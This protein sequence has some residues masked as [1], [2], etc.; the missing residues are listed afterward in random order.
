MGLTGEKTMAGMYRRARKSRLRLVATAA[1]AILLVAGCGS[2]GHSSERAASS[3]PSGAASTGSSSAPATSVSFNLYP[4]TPYSWLLNFAQGEGFFAKNGIKANLVPTTG[5]PPAFAGLASGSLQFA[6][7][8]MINGGVLLDNGTPLELVSGLM[9]GNQT[10]LI[11]SQAA[12]LPSGFPAGIKG[13]AGKD[14]GVVSVGSAAYYYMHLFLGAAGMSPNSVTYAATTVAPASLV[15][16]LSGDRV[17]AAVVSLATGYGL[18][19]V[20]HDPVL[21]DMD[22]NTDSLFPGSV[23]N[24]SMLPAGAPLQLL[25]DRVHQYLWASKP[26][27]QAHSAVVKR[28]QLALEETDVWLHNPTNLQAAVNYLLNDGGVVKFPGETAEQL[29]AFLATEV[30]LLVSYVP[31]AD[32]ATYQSVYVSQGILKSL[33]LGQ[34]MA[35]GVPA[36]SADVVNAVDA[37]GAGSLGI[38]G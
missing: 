37:A 33:P 36:S 17:A 32:V 3:G 2:S 9:K 15:A 19:V 5:A 1:A 12:H 23:P 10:L 30:P 6:S 4:G 29:Q 16:A 20:D 7:G 18:A 14:V 22:I 38:A 34:F 26:W 11:G 35:P 25:A 24:P 13:L 28:V 21:F 31:P 8:D 27:A